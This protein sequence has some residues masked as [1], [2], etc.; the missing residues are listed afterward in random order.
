MV[1]CSVRLVGQQVLKPAANGWYLVC[2][3][4]DQWHYP[5]IR[6]TV[7][8]YIYPSVSK[9]Q[10]GF[11]RVSVILRAQT[12]TTG[13]LTC[14]RDHYYAC[15]CTRGLG[16]PTASQH[17]S[18][19]EKLSQISLVLLTGFEP[20]VIES[21]DRCSTNRVP[22]SPLWFCFNSTQPY[23]MENVPIQ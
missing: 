14:I 22:L 21:W 11:V 23:V 2:T 16:T 18:D 17:I 3:S 1:A 6:F 15:V 13:S 20:W 8:K 9:V 12:W 4:L 10:A 19:S 7:Q 5:T